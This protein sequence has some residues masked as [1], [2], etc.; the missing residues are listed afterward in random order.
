MFIDIESEN[1][2]ENINNVIAN[3]AAGHMGIQVVEVDLE[4]I[5]LEM[6]ITAKSRQ[7]MGMLHGGVSMLLAE[8]A[9]SIHAGV[10]VDLS[11]KVPV[12]I[13]ING[14]HV[15]SATSGVVKAVGKVVRKTRNLIFHKVDIY[16]K[17]D[18]R[19]L[20]TGRVTNFY[21]KV[22]RE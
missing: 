15:S 5:V 6:E 22:G 14:S 1:W 20:S 7:P 13:E 9:A 17:E 10:G 18:G 8:T 16:Q 21:R 19:L 2:Q 11:E 12:G 3:T 4:H